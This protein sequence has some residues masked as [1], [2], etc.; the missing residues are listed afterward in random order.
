MSTTLRACVAR[1]CIALSV[2]VPVTGPALAQ[3]A[4]GLDE[5]V[6]TA[7]KRAESLQDVPIS[8]TA[9]TSEELRAR[10]IMDLADVAAATPGMIY[11]E[12]LNA[13]LGT[14]VVRGLSQTNLTAVDR[15]VAI[16]YR[17]IFLSN[18][19]ASNFDL[20]DMGRIEVLKGPQS[21]LYGQNAFAGAINYVPAE[22]L[23]AF[24]GRVE[25][26]V[27]SDERYEVKGTV[28]LPVSD[29]LAMRLSAGYKSFDGT[30]GNVADPRNNL[31]GFRTKSAG[32][33][34]A[35]RP[36]DSFRASFFGFYSDDKQESSAAFQVDNNCGAAPR[37][38]FLPPEVPYVGPPTHFC[39]P[40]PTRDPVSIDPRAIGNERDVTLLGLELE[41]D[42][43]PVILSSL[44]GWVQSENVAVGDY[45]LDAAGTVFDIV[46]LADVFA[47]GLFAAPALRQQGIPIFG[48]PGGVGETRDFSQELRLQSAADQRLRWM[49]GLFFYDT[50]DDEI[51]TI[52]LDSAGLAPGEIP[53]TFFALLPGVL[54]TDPAFGAII[55]EP[56]RKTRS[57]SVFGSTDY[58]LRENL[59][60]GTEL[61]YTREKRSNED[62][63]AE[64]SF[65]EGTFNHWTG[66]LSLDYKPAD[67]H[68]L[69]AFAARGILSGF[70]NDYDV[71]AANVLPDELVAYDPSSNW[72]FEVGAKSNWLDGSVQTTL[73]LFYI[74]Y[75]DLQISAVPP[76]PFQN[77]ITANVGG[78]TSKGVELDTTWFV[79]DRMVLQG[80]YAYADPKYRA[81]T[82]DAGVNRIC[83]GSD[84][85]TNEVGGNTLT[86]ASKHQA[87]AAATVFGALAG[88][89]NW[90]L[91]A[92]LSYQS[93]QYARSVNLQEIPSRTLV[94]ARI[95]LRQGERLEFAL[96]SRNL[97]DR[98]YVA[99]SIAQPRLSDF[100]FLTQSIQGNG[101][102]WGVTASYAF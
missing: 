24:G 18:P 28:N 26:T 96:W 91:R 71:F 86:R 82:V 36:N 66:R 94:N 74:D 70:F 47:V 17:G 98:S 34:I 41:W 5:I 83:N 84:L 10:S 46:N 90:S 11:F 57:W 50:E 43:G 87:T 73:A 44:T 19:Y 9:F 95:A 6:V 15:N 3:G 79:G 60:L 48:T 20:L 13:S 85:C 80:T 52:G 69:Y 40:V 31:Q 51:G 22:A 30:F 61:R 25:G 42:F 4:A 12:T 7:R 100:V 88:D 97:F 101:R 102:T 93:K 1:A 62:V 2:A 65:F 77:N 16:F 92:D 81:G 38:P 76:P 29:A 68:L 72:T 33:D 35:F 55:G 53:R 67:E 64:G 58:D 21:A 14:P 39:G 89:W 59:K 32:W 99:T 23:D 56:L 37:P 63:L 45:D 8:I 27:G 49:T 78:A 54:S 75:Q